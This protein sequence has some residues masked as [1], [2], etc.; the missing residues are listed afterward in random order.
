L[1]GEQANGV[2]SVIGFLLPSPG[3][4]QLVDGLSLSASTAPSPLD[5]A[6][7]WVESNVALAPEAQPQYANGTPYAL[8]RAQGT[9]AGPGSFG[10]DG[11]FRFALSGAEIEPVGVRDLSLRL[12][13]DNSDL[14]TNQPVRIQGQLLADDEGAVLVERLGPGGVPDATALQIKLAPAIRDSALLD[15]LNASPNR[16]VFYGPV[17]VTGIWRETRLYPLL[18]TTP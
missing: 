11:N 5:E 15:R 10:P 16:N 8:V 4:A 14:Y 9:L 18:V 12:L 3:G 17:T 7:I 1:L 2:I 13:F 6:A